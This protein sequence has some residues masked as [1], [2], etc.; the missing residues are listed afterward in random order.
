MI[1]EK[2]H[3]CST[4]PHVCL[5]ASNISCFDPCVVEM[6]KQFLDESF[7]SVSLLFHG[8][9]VYIGSYQRIIQWNLVTD[10]VVKLDGYSSLNL[11]HF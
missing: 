4:S 2:S 1:A 11:S 8:D 9:V 3:E 5:L 7:G 10:S 6:I